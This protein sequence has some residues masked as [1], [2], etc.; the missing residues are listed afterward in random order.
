MSGA[1]PAIAA[2]H[3]AV[4]HLTVRV[5]IVAVLLALTVFHAYFAQFSSFMEF[6]DEGYMMIIVKHVLDGG[7][8]YDEVPTVYGP[9]YFSVRLLLHGMAGVPLSN[10]SAR[11]ITMVYW[12]ATSGVVGLVSWRLTR[13][14]TLAVIGYMAAFF[15]LKIIATEPAH[16][17]EMVVLLLALTAALATWVDPERPEKIAAGL[18]MAAAGLI[19]IKINVGTFAVVSLV[20][21][22]M[23]SVQGRSARAASAALVVA[24]VLLPF[25]VIRHF[26][27]VTWGLSFALVVASTFASSSLVA[28]IAP[29]PFPARPVRILGAF[30]LAAVATA[31][32]LILPVLA[33]GTTLH[34]VVN[35]LLIWPAHLSDVYISPAWFTKFAAGWAAFSAVLALAYWRLSRCSEAARIREFAVVV[36][37]AALGVAVLGTLWLA[38]PLDLRTQYPL[39]VAKYVTPFLWLVLVPPFCGGPGS[40]FPR[41]VLVL[42]AAL[43]VLQGYP[44]A[45]GQVTMGTFLYVPIQVVCLGDTLE[46]AE[47]R[48]ASRATAV[49]VLNSGVLVIALA[50][51]ALI[52]WRGFNF[53][54]FYNDRGSMVGS[55]VPGAGRV[56]SDEKAAAT[57]QWLIANLN[58]HAD[59]FES[60]IDMNSLFLWTGMSPPS[61]IVIGAT[62]DFYNDEQ[63]QLV[64]QGLLRSPKACVIY[65]PQLYQG[66]HV[67]AGVPPGPLLKMVR[68]EFKS[69][70][71]V[72]QYDFCVRKGRDFPTLVNCVRLEPHGDNRTGNAERTVTGS[73]LLTAVP[74]RTASR[75]SVYDLDKETILADTQPGGT[76]PALDVEASG[77]PVRLQSAGSAGLDLS[78]ER[79]LTL[80]FPTSDPLVTEHFLVVRLLDRNG[81]LIKSIPFLKPAVPNAFLAD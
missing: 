62:L 6:D 33:W 67:P 23:L 73:L 60:T 70:G 74:G 10:H 28:S 77:S 14:A 31:T 64:V 22:L 76:I 34:G 17:Q 54:Q 65:H 7:K 26:L 12:L 21:A 2:P 15:Y 44:C 66:E 3:H 43:Q 41:S 81:R 19:M 27:T 39:F 8:L 25:A 45:G 35:A 78:A 48:F 24:A 37:K 63:Q 36:G 46:W 47:R 75:L 49:R 40:V 59:T 68:E 55:E 20:S 4:V 16:P 9:L 11:W 53:Y 50:I 30:S 61:K 42:L 1:T 5:A 52:G 29:R 56:R 38:H 13:R 32:L 72:N 71:S 58:R 80:A 79:P 18:G 69:C 51:V 57:Y